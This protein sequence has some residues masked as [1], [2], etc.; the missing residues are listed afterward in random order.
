VLERS[1]A[2]D[3]GG[4][5][6]VLAP[7]GMTAL[8]ALGPAVARDVRAAGSVA[9][10]GH[11]SAFLTARG[12]TLSSVSFAGFAQRWG[13]PAVSLRRA[14]LHAVLAEHAARAGVVVR[15]GCTVDGWTDRDAGVTVDGPDGDLLDGDLLVGA[16]GLRSAV[17][18]RLLG[19]GEPV[20]RGCTSVR[21][22]GPKAPGHPDGSIVYGRGLILF[23]APV[24]DE[25]VYWV[26]SIVA[27]AGRWPAKGPAAAHRDLLDALRGWHPDLVVPVAAADPEQLVLTD[28][29][30]RDPVRT[31]HRGRVVLLG[32]AAH[33]MTYTLGQGANQALEDAVVLAHHLAHEP[34]VDAALAAY[35]AARTARTAKVVRTSRAMGRVGHARNPLAAAARDAMMRLVGRAGDPDRQNAELFGWRPP[36]AQDASTAR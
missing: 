31:W 19:D 33:P 1:P 25:H 30:D 2:P 29:H 28:I 9:G 35:C 22:I 11:R 10:P 16:D 3:A 12:R 17:R 5:G 27:P 8:A 7:N 23:T 21:G 13:A 6:L 24:D 15:T 18:R 26:A 36:A 20:Y 4:S 32:D 34:A 14:A